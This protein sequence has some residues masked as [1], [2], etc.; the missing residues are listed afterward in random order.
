M[1]SRELSGRDRVQFP[2]GDCLRLS[3][4]LLFVIFLSN[5]FGTAHVYAQQPLGAYAVSEDQLEPAT[6]GAQTATPPQ[7]PPQPKTSNDPRT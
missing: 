3:R 1:Q 5:A 7:D 6:S 4:V 2:P